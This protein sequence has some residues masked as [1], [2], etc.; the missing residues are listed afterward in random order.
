MEKA[1]H[2]PSRSVRTTNRKGRSPIVLLCDH[3]SNFIPDG[4][5][6]LGLA[7]SRGLPCA[8]IEIRN[9]EISEDEQQRKWAER[10]GGILRHIVAEGG[11]PSERRGDQAAKLNI[12][13]D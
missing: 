13:G 2:S 12:R 10:L 3:A 7:R 5:G 9:D 6:T 11:M 8:M 4:P 1:R